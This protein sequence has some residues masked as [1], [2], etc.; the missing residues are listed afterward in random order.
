MFAQCIIGIGIAQTSQQCKNLILTFIIAEVG[1]E[2]E[3]GVDL[4]LLRGIVVELD[5]PGI[6]RG[7]LIVD[8]IDQ[9]LGR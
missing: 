9:V 8:Q 3:V 4:V 5:L 1:A 7:I 2:V 6:K